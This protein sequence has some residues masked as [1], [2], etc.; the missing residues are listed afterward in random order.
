MKNNQDGANEF[1]DEEIDLIDDNNAISLNLANG[2]KRNKKFNDTK[3][4]KNRV[5]NNNSYACS[6]IRTRNSKMNE[7]ENHSNK[8]NKQ[9]LFTS[10]NNKNSFYTENVI[11][12]HS[13]TPEKNSYEIIIDDIKNKKEAISN[14]NKNSNNTN[15]LIPHFNFRALR[16]SSKTINSVSN[17]TTQANN[18]INNNNHHLNSNNHFKIFMNNINNNHE[19]GKSFGQ[20]NN[21]KIS[22]YY[23][24]N[25]NSNK[26][27]SSNKKSLDNFN[28]A[29]TS[30]EFFDDKFI[31]SLMYW[32]NENPPGC[33]FNNLGNTC[34]LNSVLQCILYTPPLKNYF[35]HLDHSQSCE[36]N[37][38]CFLC[39]YG[40]LSKM[41]GIKIIL[42]NNFVFN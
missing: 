5:N 3:L 14:N 41:I 31:D 6:I 29:S 10:K 26:R 28:D 36:I 42:L 39:E 25:N 1:Y 33:G 38:V 18:N 15:R 4:R 32:K 9:N 34:F 37:G 35:D 12:L 16:S 20:H 27:N 22:S 7:K 19:N 17:E 13:D 2:G 40:K 24:R 21:N 11:N 8:S 30:D 23:L